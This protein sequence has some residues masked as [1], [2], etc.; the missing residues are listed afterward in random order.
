MTSVTARPKPE[1]APV[2]SHTFEFEDAI[3]EIN[4]LEKE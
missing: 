1:D 3:V 2:T 4:R